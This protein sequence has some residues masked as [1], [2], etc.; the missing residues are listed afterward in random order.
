MP[1][2]DSALKIRYFL[3]ALGAL[4]AMGAWLMYDLR[5]MSALRKATSDLSAGIASL[6]TPEKSVSLVKPKQQ[7]ASETLDLEKVANHLSQLDQVGGLSEMEE[8][9]R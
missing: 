8:L 7:L 4:F 1:A 5:E 9:M 3:T 2:N 6:E